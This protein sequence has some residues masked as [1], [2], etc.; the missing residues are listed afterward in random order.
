MDIFRQELREALPAHLRDLLTVEWIPWELVKRRHGDLPNDPVLALFSAYKCVLSYSYPIASLA[1][2]KI[3]RD[4][5]GCLRCGT[6]CTHMRPG[7]VSASTYRRWK[8]RRALVSEFYA[9]VGKGRNPRHTCWF[10]SGV[11]LRL[12]PLLFCNLVDG[13]PFCSIHHLGRGHRPR[14]CARFQPNPPLCSTGQVLLVP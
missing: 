3:P 6:C 5:S 8:E 4:S 1:M 9:P 12:C 10:F 14:A 7:A 13:K 2:Q 11:R